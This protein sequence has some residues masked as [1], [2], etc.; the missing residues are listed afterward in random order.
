MPV[1]LHQRFV[2]GVNVWAAGSG[3]LL[4]GKWQL[5]D[6]QPLANASQA[7]L[8]RA[9]ELAQRWIAPIDVV[10]QPGR[11]VHQEATRFHVFVPCAHE[12]VGA[13]ALAQALALLCQH[14][15]EPG[16]SRVAQAESAF[17]QW[18]RP[19]VFDLSTLALVRAAQQ[20][21]IPHYAMPAGRAWVQLGQG[22]QALRIRET[23]S[24]RTSSVARLLAGDKL[25]T[26]RLLQQH[27]LPNTAARLVT[28]L[29]QALALARELAPTA[30]VIKPRRGSKGR[31]VAVALTQPAEIAAAF[32]EAQSFPGEGGVVAERHVAG[33][34]HRLLVVA[35][36]LVAAARR[37]PASVE[38]NAVD[39]VAT[40][41]A[42]LN[43]DP[44]RGRPFESLLEFVAL[45]A[46]ARACLA[47]Q[48]LT[49]DS[50]PAQGQRVWLRRLANI[51]Q[52][53]TAVDVTDRVHPEVARMIERAVRLVGLDV[54][55]VDY[56]SPDIAQSWRQNDSAI[57]EINPSPG[58]RPH[59]IANPQAAVADAVLSAWIPAGVSARV[60]TVGVTGSLG[61][62]TTTHW[63]AHL[64]KLAGHQVAVT[65]TQGAWLGA[66]R[67]SHS[68]SSGGRVA[69][70]MLADPWV[71]AGAFEFARGALLKSGLGLDAISVGI[72]LNVRPNHL[73][74]DG[75]NYLDDLARVKQLVVQAATEGVVLNADDALCR[76]MLQVRCDTTRVVWL[77]EH[78]EDPWVLAHQ[79]AGGAVGVL[80]TGATPRLRFLVGQQPW[81]ECDFTALP[82]SLSGH[83]IP[84]AWHALAVAAA[85][86]L[87]GLSPDVV[88]Q[89]WLG[90]RSDWHN[91]P[92]R[93]NV[94][95][96]LPHTLVASFADGPEAVE[97]VTRLAAALPAS[98][99][100]V[101]VLTA[102]GDRPDSFIDAC[103]EAARHPGFD[104]YV[105]TDWVK[106][107]GRE[108]GVVAH[109][110][111]QALRRVGVAAQQ[112]HCQPDAL[113][114][115]QLATG[116]A[117]HQGVVLDNTYADLDQNGWW[118]QRG[119]S[120]SPP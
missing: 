79:Q 101:W 70:Q 13:Q 66:E 27:Q 83:F 32:A 50:V 45:D 76:T 28:D 67:V 3:Q 31:G 17:R 14:G 22:R 56:L 20:R 81:L 115:Y 114:A 39:T 65:T 100:R 18:A 26:Q 64:L 59:W 43:Q 49:P 41:V 44:R 95:S 78:P 53:G 84:A 21:G 88:R 104:A 38:G 77:T 7:I 87:L 86:Y 71:S 98:G 102:A 46:E 106:L 1:W 24:D 16:S 120:G 119:V 12:G 40:L 112:V 54:A 82:S 47:S 107:G 61:K 96:N 91:N 11:L 69:A 34:D 60:P 36:K 23:S 110:L 94:V 52:G 72:V 108:P 2:R 37:E 29:E 113:R 118:Q 62:T 117:G 105:C 92:G 15:L 51:S 109:R 99:P 48:G 9:L 80:Q 73:G 10:T 30:L 8:T 35:G 68:E 116:L 42:A 25:A 57:L 93:T 75:L 33:H 6:E 90:F 103:A 111:A 4:V 19:R 5:P 58:L 63:V 55:G 89:S 97:V 74:Q 85:G